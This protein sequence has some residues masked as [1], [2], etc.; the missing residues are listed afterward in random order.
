MTKQEVVRKIY[1]TI[2]SNRFERWYGEGGNFDA[3]LTGDNRDGT[4]E[5]PTEDQILEEIEK[6]FSL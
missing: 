1:N 2:T 5:P 3:Y 4:A 6:L